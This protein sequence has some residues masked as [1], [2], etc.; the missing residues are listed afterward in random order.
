MGDIVMPIEDFFHEAEV[1]GNFPLLRFVAA[2]KEQGYVPVFELN[3]PRETLGFRKAKIVVQ[4]YKNGQEGDYKDDDW[5]DNLNAGLVQLG[6]KSK[7]PDEEKDRFALGL[8]AALKMPEK[9]YG[10]GYFNAMLNDFIRQT[11]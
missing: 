4:F 7:N 11:D 1:P 2:K 8:R 10:D 5:D 6:V 3:R 9:R